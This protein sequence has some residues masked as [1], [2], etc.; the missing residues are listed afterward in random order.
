MEGEAQTKIMYQTLIVLKTK[1]GEATAIDVI[2]VKKRYLQFRD[3]LKD[4]EY[5]YGSQFAL[6]QSEEL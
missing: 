2:Y 1:I 4:N 6:I 5:D 3:R